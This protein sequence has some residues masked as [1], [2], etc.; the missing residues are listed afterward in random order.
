MHDV[1]INSLALFPD[2]TSQLKD[3]VLGDQQAGVF[4]DPSHG[5]DPLKAP[6]PDSGRQQQLQ[7]GGKFGDIEG[8][9]G[10]DHVERQGG[11][12]HQ[13]NAVHHRHERPGT[14][15]REIVGLL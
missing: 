12:F 11:L 14:V 5:Y 13:R 8:I 6:E 3:I 9:D 15:P 4:T 1:F 7:H 2:E 10:G